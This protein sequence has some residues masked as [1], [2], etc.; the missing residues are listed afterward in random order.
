M[1][2]LTKTSS[3]IHILRD[4]SVQRAS[5]FSIKFRMFFL[6]FLGPAFILGLGVNSVEA[7]ALASEATCRSLGYLGPRKINSTIGVRAAINTAP[8]VVQCGVL[9]DRGDESSLL[10]APIEKIVEN[11]TS[12]QESP[13]T[14]RALNNFYS[15]MEAN[16]R[17]VSETVD[18][19]TSA[20]HLVIDSETSI[21][22]I[23]GK[24]DELRALS[25]RQEIAFGSVIL[26]GIEGSYAKQAEMAMNQAVQAELSLVGGLGT[27]PSKLSADDLM[28]YALQ[29]QVSGTPIEQLIV[30]KNLR[31]RGSINTK[32]L[33]EEYKVESLPV[34]MVYTPEGTFA[35]DGS[36]NPASFFSAFGEVD[37]SL[38]LPK[39]VPARK[40]VRKAGKNDWVLIDNQ[41]L[42]TNALPSSYSS[43]SSGGTRFGRSKSRSATDK[44]GSP[45][46]KREETLK[47][48]KGSPRK[49]ISS[50]SRQGATPPPPA[51]PKPPTQRPKSSSGAIERF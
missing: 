5:L 16:K 13:A 36:K 6:L 41:I 8:K 22:T 37:T 39:G 43:G 33:L 42:P 2:H 20:V 32:R 25:K 48:G 18:P 35:F 26:L 30:R 31:R 12:Q 51:R 50:P 4:D 46:E 45:L 44:L 28:K 23:E 21:S 40:I 7:Q 14:Q 15:G 11:L 29:G 9:F 34:W 47:T 27:D 1:K 19:A 17:R 38:S 24:L 3:C 10:G 49:S